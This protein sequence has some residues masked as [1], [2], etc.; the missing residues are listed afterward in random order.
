M[1]FDRVLVTGSSGMLGRYV[2][3]ELR[4]HCEVFG[5]DLVP[6]KISLPHTVGDLTDAVAVAAACRGQS[7]IIHLAGRPNVWSGPASKIVE[8]N[9][10]GMWNVLMAAAEQ[11]VRRVVICSS[12][13]VI[14]FTVLTG[15][16]CPPEYLPIDHRHPCRPTDPYGLSKLLCEETGRSFAE[17]GNLDIVVIRPVFVLYPEMEGEVRARGKDPTN[18]KGP[19]V[20]GPS[21]AGGG[22]IWHYIDPRDAA[23]GFRLALEMN[24][25]R[26]EKFF[27]SANSTLAPD[28]TLVRLEKYLGRPID[29]CDSTVYQR[30]PYAP[31]YDLTHAHEVL[32]FQAQ[33]DLRAAFL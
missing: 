1:E 5:F 7:A 31:L 20:G 23:R 30:N 28:P 22:P 8:V 29:Q 24:P 21:A 25:V 12:D 13:S 26:F 11:S 4:E 16:M 2:I 33:H 19:A 32:G 14:G 6:P 9:V 27:V 3:E 17:A 15:S 18:Y 10:L